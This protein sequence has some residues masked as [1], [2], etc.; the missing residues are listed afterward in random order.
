M[1]LFLLSA[2]LLLSSCHLFKDSDEGKISLSGDKKNLSILF[3]HNINGETH[4]CGC[5]HFPLGGLPQVAGLMQEIKKE[6]H[7]IYIDSGDAL[8]P[9]SGIPDTMAKS[10]AFQASNLAGALKDLGLYFMVPGDQDF[11]L[12]VEF[13]KKT[14]IEK[15]IPLLLSNATAA[16]PLPHKKWAQIKRGQHNVFLL[17]Y[18]APDTLKP[19]E[20][21]FFY[22]HETFLKTA[23]ALLKEKGYDQKNP[24]HRLIIVSHSGM[25]NDQ[26]M[27]EKYPQINWVIGAHSQ[28]FTKFPKT[29][30]NT[31]L[32]QVLS[33]NHYMGEIII[34][35]NGNRTQDKYQLREIRDELRTKLS[36]N[37]YE[38]FIQKHK[39]KMS[40]LQMLEQSLM[41]P[42]GTKDYLYSTANS[43][44]ECHQT[45]ANFWGGTA[46][47]IAL[48]TL[49]HAKE[50]NNQACIGCHTLGHN[51]PHGFQKLS[52]IVKLRE[53]DEGMGADEK[54]KSQEDKKLETLKKQYLTE[55]KKLFV[56]T[57]DIREMS[58]DKIKV[59]KKKWDQLDDTHKVDFN[60]ANVQ[61]LNCHGQ[62]V[63]HPFDN[64]ARPT[65]QAR[66]DD[67]QNRCLKCHNPDQSPEWYNRDKRGLPGKLNKE[68]FMGFYQKVSCPKID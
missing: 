28:S 16:N 56:H 19:D 39:S 58:S 60:F 66:R 54:N 30:G 20:R 8:F 12:G 53:D 37:P 48:G 35:L 9:S 67:I 11:A 57:K 43:C 4:P 61:C 10:L 65:A 55:V 52:D 21:P 31:Q 6:N 13:L 14:V 22:G 33:R 62:H 50:E 2:L 29:S 7:L 47:S 64:G 3:S 25:E 5:R 45:Q 42:Q 15:E 24:F 41:E 68:K 32:V 59:I 49:F 27:V 23:L 40:E 18:V 51:D 17:G 46:H 26:K 44:L 1:R 34:S 36:P 38:A 63:D